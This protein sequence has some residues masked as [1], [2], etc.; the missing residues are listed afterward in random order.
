MEAALGDLPRWI[1]ADLTFHNQ[2][3]AMSHNRLLLLQVQGLAPVIRNVMDRFN[4]R[5]SRNRAEWRRTWD[6]HG[7]IVDAVAARDPASA[8]QAM[9]AHFAAAD[10]ALAELFQAG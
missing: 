3:A 7:V 8:E 4:A 9:S 10:A 6:R 5:T 1:N 2:L